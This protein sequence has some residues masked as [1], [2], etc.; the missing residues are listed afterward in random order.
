MRIE[1]SR[2]AAIALMLPVAGCS[3]APAYRP[4]AIA[5]PAAYKEIPG[6]TAAA[7]QDDAPRGQWWSAFDDPVLD[8]LEKRAEQA[9]PTLA[10]AL[11]RYDAARAAARGTAA[12]LFPEIDVSGNAGRQQVSANRPLGN[13]AVDP[14]DNY[15]VGGSLS[16]EIDLWG[17]VRNS[18]KAA[19]ADAQASAGDLAAAR[20]SLQ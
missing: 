2:A 5:T 7:P 13:G 17:R 12:G 16:Y 3:M 4:P 14:Y 19:R 6:W 1:R 10:E 11:A 18:V 15:V 9:S 8:D 20:L